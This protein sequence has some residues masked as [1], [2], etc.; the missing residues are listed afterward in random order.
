MNPIQ[1]ALLRLAG[2][3]QTGPG[4]GFIVTGQQG[5]IYKDWTSAFAIKEGYKASSVIA[6]C[7]DRRGDALASVPLRAYTRNPDGEHEPAPDSPLQA[8]L[9]N[10]NPFMDS[11]FMVRRVSDHLLLAG[12]AALIKNRGATQ[13]QPLELWPVQP[14]QITPIINPNVMDPL[15][16]YRYHDLN[17]RQTDMQRDQVVHLMRP[18]PETPYWGIGALQSGFRAVENEKAAIDWQNSMLKRGAIT[19]GIVGVEQ[20][21]TDDT[22]KR[23]KAELEQR[24]L[25]NSRAGEELFVDGVG[26][27]SFHRTSL[28][29]NEL[30]LVDSRRVT[31]EDI[32]SMLQ[33]PPPL[34]GYYEN[35]TLA[36]IETARQIFWL[37]TIIPFARMLASMLT[38]SLAIDFGPQYIID[39]DFS[40]VDALQENLSDKLANWVTLVQN[41]MTREAASAVLDLGWEPDMFTTPEGG[42]NEDD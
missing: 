42:T 40:D 41:G 37:D 22:Y 3:K 32:M 11:T 15:A 39:F 6:A 20:S 5:P 8:L 36:N 10:P 9:S 25:G 2:I 34:V 38:R 7:I 27:V 13:R 23:L 35:A 18:N 12:N 1:K 21:L 24:R 28:N 31:R 4:P 33:V 17:G 26:A 16:G 30:A 14:D 19:G 29:A